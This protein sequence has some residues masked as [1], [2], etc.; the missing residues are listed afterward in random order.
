MMIICQQ[1]KACRV[2]IRV[3]DKVSAYLNNKK[4]RDVV[5]IE[6]SSGVAIQIL[7]SE[8][9]FP[10]HFECDCRDAEGNLIALPFLEDMGSK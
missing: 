6:E 3:N 8:A 7:G 9:L 2:T 1:P 10:E 5:Q 4:R